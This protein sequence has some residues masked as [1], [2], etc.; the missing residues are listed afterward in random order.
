LI[1]VIKLK[2][3]IKNLFIDLGN[4]KIIKE[5]K[6]ILEIKTKTAIEPKLIVGIETSLNIISIV[7]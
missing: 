6:Y 5:P 7:L 1:K 3:I 2:I 4:Y